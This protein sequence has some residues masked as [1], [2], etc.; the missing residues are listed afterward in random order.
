M[1]SVVITILLA[2]LVAA[3]PIADM[4]IALNLKYEQ[5]EKVEMRSIEQSQ[6]DTQ[7]A[8]K[9]AERSIAGYNKRL[10]RVASALEKAAKRVVEIENNITI[11]SAAVTTA[12]LKYD[13]AKKAD[14]N[15]TVVYAKEL[16]KFKKIWENA[17]KQ[18]AGAVNAQR[19]LKARQERLNAQVKQLQQSVEK[20]TEVLK[21]FDNQR[22]ELQQRLKEEKTEEDGHRTLYL[23]AVEEN[24]MMSKE[25]RSIESGLG[26]L[27][28]PKRTRAHQRLQEIKEATEKNQKIIKLQKMFID[29][30]DSKQTSINN[31]MKSINKE[32]SKHNLTIKRMS[33]KLSHLK[34]VEKQ[35]KGV[36][37]GKKRL[38]QLK[39]DEDEVK[40]GIDVENDRHEQAIGEYIRNIIYFRISGVRKE[41]EALRHEKKV[42]KTFRRSV[43]HKRCAIKEGVSEEIK[44]VMQKQQQELKS[45]VAATSGRIAAVN[46]RIASLRTYKQSLHSALKKIAANR[47]KDAN[48]T[49]AAQKFTMRKYRKQLEAMRLQNKKGTLRGEVENMAVNYK[50]SQSR[51]RA[52]RSIRDEAERDQR[53]VA[54]EMFREL[55]DKRN[56]LNSIL[57]E[58]DYRRKRDAKREQKLVAAMALQPGDCFARRKLWKKI[59]R[60]QAS[61]K[62]ITKRIDRVSKKIISLTQRIEKE[63]TS[64]QEV[65]KNKNTR[66]VARK[67]EIQ[68]KIA[69]IKSQLKKQN[70]EKKYRA[71]LSRIRD[72]KG[73]IKSIMDRIV[74]VRAEMRKTAAEVL[75]NKHRRQYEIKHSIYEHTHRKLQRLR[76]KVAK[77]TNKIMLQQNLYEQTVYEKRKPMEVVINVMK[78]KRTKL[79]ARIKKLVKKEEKSEQAQIKAA[80]KVVSF[81]RATIADTKRAQKEYVATASKKSTEYKEHYDHLAGIAANDVVAM[82][83]EMA[84]YKEKI[85][86]FNAKLVAFQS[87]KTPCKMCVELGRR[88]KESLAMDMDNAQLLR[89]VQDRCK[90]FPENER[91]GCY[92]MAFKVAKYAANL[93]DPQELKVKKMC[94][95]LRGCDMF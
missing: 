81:L 21:T 2:A 52:L 78:E 92:S 55:K 47:V 20:L 42:L 68:K 41:I 72:L 28:G 74:S 86:R 84:K 94:V 1:K 15:E 25:A 70:N 16:D 30:I 4:R 56:A 34:K 95:A 76:M 18:K 12:Q 43:A 46:Q 7:A 40:N 93:F 17:K 66:L 19:A 33:K 6:K 83:R 59:Q 9:R 79:E 38:L 11:A 65:L 87:E 29:V 44:A 22:T 71:S 82:K 50:R 80:E 49:L 75:L 54:L 57:R 85:E 51:Y 58:L 73:D 14:S 64:L 3:S 62:K 45:K 27:T 5:N 88:A 13:A 35:W 37:N 23:T 63:E 10:E 32:N 36:K 91:G 26:M 69:M 48:S 31:I 60:V 39:R 77:L 89:N 53:V 67:Q 24:R 90:Y 61:N 8:V